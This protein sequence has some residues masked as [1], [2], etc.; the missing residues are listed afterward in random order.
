MARRVGVELPITD[1]VCAVLAGGEVKDLA[2]ELMG[3][4]PTGEWS[5]SP[6]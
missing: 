4:K 2:V 6:V 3:R 1:A 5:A